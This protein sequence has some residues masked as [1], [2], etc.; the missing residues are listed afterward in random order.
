[1]RDE[2]SLIIEYAIADAD[3]DPQMIRRQRAIFRK[4]QA[5][6]HVD[7][8]HRRAKE[9]I[10]CQF[11]D[12]GDKFSYGPIEAQAACAD[13]LSRMRGSVGHVEPI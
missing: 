13:K 8:I 3:P 2:V 7:G 11:G 1:V 6:E 9:R 12:R 4:N 5:R 10:E